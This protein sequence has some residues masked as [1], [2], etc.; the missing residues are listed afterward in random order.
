MRIQDRVDI[1]G[2]QGG[3]HADMPVYVLSFVMGSDIH[4]APAVFHIHC[5]KKIKGMSLQ[6]IPSFDHIFTELL[7]KFIHRLVGHKPLLIRDRD[8]G[9]GLFRIISDQITL[10]IE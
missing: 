1:H 3:A 9:F 7:L 4:G 6:L 5:K 2:V 10:I 8:D